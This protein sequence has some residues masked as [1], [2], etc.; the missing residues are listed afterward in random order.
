MVT[1]HIDHLIP[2]NITRSQPIIQKTIS[3]MGCV[4]CASW[5]FDTH[6]PKDFL[7]ISHNFEQNRRVPIL[8]FVVSRQVVL[9]EL[10]WASVNG[11]THVGK[12]CELL[13][14]LGGLDE[15]AAGDRDLDELRVEL[16]GEEAGDHVGDLGDEVRVEGVAGGEGLRGEAMGEAG[17]DH[18]DGVVGREGEVGEGDVR[19]ELFDDG[20]EDGVGEA[21]EGTP[22]G[23]AERGFE[24]PDV[25]GGEGSEGG[26]GHGGGGG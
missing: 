7:V 1:P 6:I 4:V 17:E 21:V 14:S 15:S 2:N 22:L 3:K 13:E 8:A 25:L 12:R 5:S 9:V 16:G 10:D 19:P 26:D 18:G 23:V 11:A 20:G 24:G